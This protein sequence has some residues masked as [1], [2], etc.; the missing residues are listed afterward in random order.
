MG[1]FLPEL[2][3]PFPFTLFGLIGMFY[4]LHLRKS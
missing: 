4:D 2:N 3:N 1:E